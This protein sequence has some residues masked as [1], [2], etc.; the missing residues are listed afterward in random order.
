MTLPNVV[1]AWLNRPAMR[2]QLRPIEMAP[3]QVEQLEDRTLL[4]GVVDGGTDGEPAVQQA[5]LEGQTTGL[6]FNLPGASDGY[7]LFSPNGTTTTYLLDKDANIVNEWVSA[8]PPGLHAYLLEDGSLVRAASAESNSQIIANGGGGLIERFDWDGNKVWE[9]DYNDD[10]TFA[11]AVLQHHDFEIMPNGNILMIAWETMSAA[12]AEQ[13][14]RDD[15]LPGGGAPLFPDHIVEVEPDLLAGVGGTIVW[16]WHAIDHLIQDHDPTK[17]NFGVVADHPELIDFNYVA[18]QANGGGPPDDWIH[19]NGI[20]YN[21]DLDQIVL[22][23]REFSEFWVIDHS[24]TTAEAAGH[25][26]GNSG[27][28]GDLLY[29]WGNPETYG[30]GD[31]SDRTLFFQHDPK[32]IPAGLPGA[33]NITVFNNGLGQP[34]EDLSS[35]LEIAPPVDGSGNYS[36][37]PGEAYGPTSA[38]FSYVAPADDF[39]AIISGTQRLENG[40]TLITFGVDGTIVEVTS[41]GE[42]VWKYVN[43]YT[44]SGELG[45]TD[46]IPAFPFPFLF[47]NFVFRATDYATD[48][49]DFPVVTLTASAL[50]ND[51]TPEVTVRATGNGGLPDGTAVALDVD[52]NNDGDFDDAGETDYTAGTLTSGFAVFD[53]APSLADG[54]YALQARVTD[55]GA[56]EGTSETQSVIVDTTGPTVTV[57]GEAYLYFADEDTDSI[58]RSDLNGNNV[59]T[60]VPGAVDPRGLAIDP[61]DGKLYWSDAGSV[62]RTIQRANLDGSNVETLV[63]FPTVPETLNEIALDLVNGKIYYTNS[64][65]GTVF[66]ANLDGTNQETIA[67]GVPDPVGIA[68]DP[69]GGHVYWTGGN[70]TSRANLDGTGAT[71]ILSFGARDLAIDQATGKLYIGGDG[72]TIKRSDLDGTNVELLV[73]TTGQ[74]SQMGVDFASGKIYWSDLGTDTIQRANLDGTNVEDVITT[75]LSLPRDIAFH[76]EALPLLTSDSTPEV[77]VSAADANNL[78]D[79]TLVTLDVDLTGDGDFDDAGEAGYTTAALLSGSATFEIAPAL[80]EGS[81]DVQA[82]VSDTA[83]NEGTSSVSTVNV[84]TLFFTAVVNGQRELWKTD[85]TA[86]GT[87]RVKN[88]DGPNSSEPQDL[89]DV[90]G[91]LFFTALSQAGAQRE[92]WMSDGTLAGTQLVR[93]LNGSASADPDQLT[94]VGNTLFFVATHNGQR[95]LW[96]SDGTAAGTTRVKNLNGPLDSDPEE[97]T[98]VGGTLF[99]TALANGQR[100]LW[101]SDGTAGGTQLVKNID[102]PNSSEPQDLTDVDGTLFFTALS[103]GGTQRE[104]WMSDGTSGG[105]QRVLN[106]NGPTSSDPRDLT[107]VGGTLFFTAIAAGERE[108]WMSDGTTAGTVLVRDLND[109]LGSDPLDL[110]NVGGTLFFTALVDGQRELWKSNGTSAGTV[111]VKNISGTES[112][113]PQGLTNVDGRLFFTAMSQ[114]G[115]QRELWTSDGT[116]AGTVQVSNLNGPTS[117]HPDNLTAVGNRLF[118]SATHNGDRELWTS[119]GTSAGTERVRNL[120]GAESSDPEQLTSVGGTDDSWLDDNTLTALDRYVETFDPSYGYSFETT[121]VGPGFTAHVL[122]MTSQTWMDASVVDKPVWQHWVTIIVPDGVTSDTAILFVDGGSTGGAPSSPDDVALAIAL[123]TGMTVIHL[124]TVPNQP[125]V[126]LEEGVPRSEDEIIAW[127]FDKYYQTGDDTYPLLLP[128]VKSA[129]AAMNTG[130]DYAQS[131]SFAINDFIVTGASKR[132]WTTWLTAAVDSRVKAISPLVIDVL[133]MDEQMAHHRSNYEGVTEQIS[134][135]YSTAVHDYVDLNIMDRLGTAEAQNLLNIVDPYEY[136]DRLTQPKYIVNASGDEFFVPDSAQFYYDD[137]EGSN[138]LRYVPNVGHGLNEDALIGVINYFAAIDAGSTLPTYDWTVEDDGETI[139]VNTLET[140]VQ[141]TMWQATNPDSLD[142]RNFTFGP[143]W[144]GTTLTDQGGGEYVGQVSPPASGGTAFFVEL[145]YSIDGRLLTFTSEVSIVEAIP[146]LLSQPAPSSSRVAASPSQSIP[147]GLNAQLVAPTS[148]F[149][150]SSEVLNQYNSI[151]EYH[152]ALQPVLSQIAETGKTLTDHY[153]QALDLEDFP[154][155]DALADHIAEGLDDLFSKLSDPHDDSPWLGF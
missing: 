56:S 70:E 111:R 97:L 68:V 43:P 131:Q 72:N 25:S 125:L 74:F 67:S 33:G 148:G 124:P 114:G 12:E 54:T 30:A 42:Q 49:F 147:T 120:N 88:I 123:Q 135:G 86:A 151:H 21:A 59:I 47:E 99:F 107:N 3:L 83:G 130:Q 137:L 84:G 2:T 31:A 101:M 8:Y 50:T 29:R 57:S 13:A 136:R 58:R 155:L 1:A 78:P 65:G 9:F 144:T 98:D 134:G 118:F 60:I 143:G 27:K 108:L 91:T 4:S 103:Q 71:V 10:S 14:G 140:P 109:A 82:R 32:W 69:I 105:T 16:E 129:V 81:Y 53:V 117:S 7:T 48:F 100:E 104:L 76:R 132:G 28:G 23:S 152:E 35:V 37:T 95:E 150:D 11:D 20:D 85:G 90:G 102:G 79:G 77:T 17:D 52:L 46:P 110:T 116:T 80:A 139:R 36:L 93:N 34:G 146:S 121:L 141:V 40:N 94:A 96:Q 26:G 51:A 15:T 133:N 89:T 122:D 119:D 127:T 145:V 154:K 87:V 153:R 6:F 126:F 62:P 66:R 128:M 41:A 45:P 39:S 55:L 22:S 73:T 63:S 138:Y 113:T 38:V 115:S 44:A 106:I 18:D 75:G 112:G 142:F 149:S 19:A 92:L 24:T 64:L 61:V 5:A